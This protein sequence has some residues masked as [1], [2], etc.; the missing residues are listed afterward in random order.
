MLLLLDRESC[1]VTHILPFFPQSLC[2]T[3]KNYNHYICSQ[4][5]GNCG[6]NC[7]NIG[8]FY[9]PGAF[10]LMAVICCVTGWR[11]GNVLGLFQ[12][13]E[14]NK[15]T[16]RLSVCLLYNGGDSSTSVWQPTIMIRLKA[17][18][19]VFPHLLWA[20]NTATC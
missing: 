19:I 1:S 18:K 8:K 3:L 11:E 2:C 5:D 7:L 13:R 14:P 4:T 6:N 15:N 17:K 10:G 12:R 16:C 20:A 9:L